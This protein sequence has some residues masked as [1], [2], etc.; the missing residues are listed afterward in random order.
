MSGR[1]RELLKQHLMKRGKN[2]GIAD[3]MAVTG[4]GQRTIER[5]I[6]GAHNPDSSNSYHLALACGCS[7]AEAREL[8]GSTPPRAKVGA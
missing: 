1:L 6:F 7:D 5:W 8:A 3:L 4:K 2:Q